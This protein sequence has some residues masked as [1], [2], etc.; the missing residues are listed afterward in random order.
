MSETFTDQYLNKLEEDEP[1][2]AYIDKESN[3]EDNYEFECHDHKNHD[4]L[5]RYGKD[6]DSHG[7]F[8]GM[9]L[10]CLMENKIK[11]Y[12]IW[13]NEAALRAAEVVKCGFQDELDN[14]EYDRYS[15][16]SSDKYISEIIEIYDIGTDMAKTKIKS[17]KS[18]TKK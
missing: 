3:K 16:Y 5:L 17:I 14:I 9:C 4:K 6:Y 12:D 7:V 1:I 13:W 2:V 18:Q 8:Y 11:H 15:F 10:Y